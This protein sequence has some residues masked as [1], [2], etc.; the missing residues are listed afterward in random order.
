MQ[1]YGELTGDVPAPLGEADRAMRDAAEAL[2]DGR[3]P[4][5]GGGGVQ[6][7]VHQLDAGER[8]VAMDLVDDAPVR[9]HVVV[10]PQGEEAI[11]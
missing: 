3:D 5:V 11:G 6:T 7:A 9:R 1:Q 10:V 2:A 4:R 8:P